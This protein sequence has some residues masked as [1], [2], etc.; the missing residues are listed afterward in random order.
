MA[1]RTSKVR[2][3]R[4]EFMYWFRNLV[5]QIM[6]NP[7]TGRVDPAKVNDNATQNKLLDAVRD[8][9]ND[10]LEGVVEF[11]GSCTAEYLSDE[12]FDDA[13]YGKPSLDGKGKA[14]YLQL[15]IKVRAGKRSFEFDFSENR[16]IMWAALEDGME[17]LTKAEQAE[18]LHAFEFQSRDLPIDEYV[19][20]V[21]SNLKA[22]SK[23][24][25]ARI[26]RRKQVVG[27]GVVK[28]KGKVVGVAV[29][30]QKHRS[31]REPSPKSSSL[32]NR[33]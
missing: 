17:S 2:F 20:Q 26:A 22:K 19:A 27:T 6:F 1:K 18:V 12:T 21:K 4:V 31:E 13:G 33:S 9:A 8:D 29:V 14:P 24:I 11:D 3:D 16:D 7:K 30:T 5:F 28:Q 32:A 15:T 25:K 23:A 10:A